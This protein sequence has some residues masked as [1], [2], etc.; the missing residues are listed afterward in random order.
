MSDTGFNRK[1]LETVFKR[2]WKERVKMN[3]DTARLVEYYL[4]MFVKEALLRGI[5]EAQAS[6]SSTVQVEHLERIIGQLLL[7]F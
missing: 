7:D 1:L 2:V 6:D 5:A 3:Q 4:L